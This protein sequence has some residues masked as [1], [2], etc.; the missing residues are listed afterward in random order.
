MKTAI[1]VGHDQ[2][3]QG[4][5]SPILN[6]TEYKFNCLLADELCKDFDIYYRGTKRG[7]LSKMNA[8]A[9]EIK[10]T[11]I[12]YDFIVEL[13][14]NMYDGK[15]NRRGHGA[16]AVI[17]PGNNESRFLANTML[18]DLT[19]NFNVVN[20]GVKERYSGQRGWGFLSR[21]P[22]NAIIWEPFFG[23]ENEALEFKDVKKHAKLLRKHLL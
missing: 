20:R 4:A 11:G 3:E 19:L 16:E 6:M 22:A 5:F 23:D 17:Y 13:H 2:V 10:N 15:A 21:M 12:N 14:F 9:K 1:V 8:L 7:Y 18:Q